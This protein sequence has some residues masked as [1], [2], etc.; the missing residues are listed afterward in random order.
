MHFSS[1]VNTAEWGGGGPT[2]AA[3]AMLGLNPNAGTDNSWQA[4]DANGYY[5]YCHPL[6]VIAVDSL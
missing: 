1:R 4:L 2:D 5:F 6:Q 3:D